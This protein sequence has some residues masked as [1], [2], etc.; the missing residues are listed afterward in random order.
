[1]VSDTAGIIT[2]SA[3]DNEFYPKKDETFS[4]Q[5][6]GQDREVF[7]ST[8]QDIIFSAYQKPN[9]NHKNH[10]FEHIMGGSDL[11]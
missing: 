11:T 2:V 4:I 3:L 5:Y 7:R 10:S 8:F 1:M 9:E 6:D